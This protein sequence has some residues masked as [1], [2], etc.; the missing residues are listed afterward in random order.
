MVPFLTKWNERRKERVIAKAML[1]GMHAEWTPFTLKFWMMYGSRSALGDEG[2]FVT[3][4][5]DGDE[6]IVGRT[7]YKCAKKYLKAMEKLK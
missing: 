4:I 7:L 5:G 1:L 3:N 6:Y 2:T